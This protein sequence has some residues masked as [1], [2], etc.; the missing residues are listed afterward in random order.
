[1]DS[2]LGNWSCRGRGKI[3]RLLPEILYIEG[4]LETTQMQHT[5]ASRLTRGYLICIAGTVFWSTTAI[6][7]RYLTE[8]YDLPAMVLAFWRDLILS[9]TLGLVFLV[10]RRVRL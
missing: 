2:S 9:L 4:S 7:I 5:A 10:F 8:T 1:M 3:I 6:F